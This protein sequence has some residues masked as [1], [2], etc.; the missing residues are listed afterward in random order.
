MLSDPLHHFIHR[1]KE[2]DKRLF[3]LF[4][5]AASA[6]LPSFVSLHY[7]WAQSKWEEEE[8]IFWGRS[9]P[10]SPRPPGRPSPVDFGEERRAMAERMKWRNDERQREQSKED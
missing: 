5:G 2:W 7:I 1:E 3:H 6:A 9:A 4:C 10:F 8:V